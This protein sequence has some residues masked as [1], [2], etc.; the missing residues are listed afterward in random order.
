MTAAL[1]GQR[2]LQSCSFYSF[3]GFC[4]GCCCFLVVAIVLQ[5]GRIDMLVPEIAL[6]LVG[7]PGCRRRDAQR[8]N[9]DDSVTRVVVAVATVP[10]K[11]TLS[12][13]FPA[14]HGLAKGFLGCLVTIQSLQVSRFQPLPKVLD[15]HG[16]AGPAIGQDDSSESGFVLMTKL[17][18]RIGLFIGNVLVQRSRSLARGDHIP[19]GKPVLG[20]AFHLGV[21]RQNVVGGIAQL[22]GKLVF[23][24]RGRRYGRG[25]AKA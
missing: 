18:N 8:R 12:F 14:C 13:R 1:K 4:C 25:P 15:K 20:E 17:T 5:T 10:A 23:F 6:L 7:I 3:V 22:A 16:T 11:V 21:V 19:Q 2:L 9:Q 24:S